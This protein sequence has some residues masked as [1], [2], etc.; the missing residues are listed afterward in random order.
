MYW[1]ERERSGVE[2]GG[3]TGAGATRFA[4]QANVCSGVQDAG[5]PLQ[6]GLGSMEKLKDDFVEKKSPTKN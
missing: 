3:V 6:V 2:R 5:T 4:E 1:R